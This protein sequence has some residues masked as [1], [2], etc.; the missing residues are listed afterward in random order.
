MFIKEQ[1]R[2]DPSSIHIF[3]IILVVAKMTM[4]RD[5]GGL[6]FRRERGGGDR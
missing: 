4:S 6:L 2:Y 3:V 5:L 1:G